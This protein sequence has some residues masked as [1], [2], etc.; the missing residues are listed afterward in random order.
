MVWTGLGLG[1]LVVVCV[2]VVA[3]LMV[4]MVCGFEVLDVR[5]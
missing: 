2:V 3:F 5:C 4:A 1:W